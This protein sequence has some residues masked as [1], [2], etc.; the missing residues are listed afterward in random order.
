MACITS[1]ERRKGSGGRSFAKEGFATRP[2]LEVGA[3]RGGVSF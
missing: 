3:G 1:I 2:G